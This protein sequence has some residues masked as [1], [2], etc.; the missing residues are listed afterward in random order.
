M[1]VGVAT[2]LGQSEALVSSPQFTP[3][4]GG[5]GGGGRVLPG[6]VG[7]RFRSGQTL[8]LFQDQNM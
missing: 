7:G 4:G 5:G 6:I 8:A 3:G 1:A 2:K